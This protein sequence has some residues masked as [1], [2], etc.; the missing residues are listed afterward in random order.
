MLPGENESVPRYDLASMETHDN[1]SPL[2]RI[3][4]LETEI[5][6]ALAD[7]DLAADADE[8]SDGHHHPAEAATDAE[9]RERQLQD[10]LRMRQQLERLTRAR[11]AIAAG[12]YGICI[13]CG[14]PI[15]EGRLL[16]I[17]DAERCVPCQ[18]I[19]ARRR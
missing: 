11:A 2:E 7:R 1:E 18:G 10:T 16:A 4:R 12:T 15:P 6:S 5:T 17:P 9:L 3:A 19:A 14:K 8:R 13:D